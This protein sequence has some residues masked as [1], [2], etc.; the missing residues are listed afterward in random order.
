[1]AVMLRT[2]IFI[3]ANLQHSFAASRIVTR[4]VSFKEL[5]IARI[6]EAWYCEIRVRGLNIPGYNLYS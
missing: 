2:L 4:T 1:V 5:D 3:H 6:Q